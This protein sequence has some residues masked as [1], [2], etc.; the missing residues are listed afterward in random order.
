M[1]DN[2]NSQV[3]KTTRHETVL[4]VVGFALFVVSIVC[5]SA[6]YDLRDYSLSAAS[7]AFYIGGSVLWSLRLSSVVSRYRAAL[8]DRVVN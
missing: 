3:K 2:K 1:T 8:G 7:S 5:S 4:Q 6:A